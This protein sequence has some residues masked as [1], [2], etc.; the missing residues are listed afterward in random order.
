MKWR[1]VSVKIWVT[2]FFKVFTFIEYRQ[3][4]IER[5]PRD[6][7]SG[8]PRVMT[9][10]FV[11]SCFIWDIFV[12]YCE[13]YSFCYAYCPGK[14]IFPK[15]RDYYTVITLQ[16]LLRSSVKKNLFVPIGPFRSL[17]S[18][19]FLESFLKVKR[20]QRFT[21]GGNKATGWKTGMQ[22]KLQWFPGGSQQ[23]VLPRKRQISLQANSYRN[24]LTMLKT[25]QDCFI[26]KW[27]SH[28]H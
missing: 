6:E 9:K 4:Q 21:T 26:S 14:T 5:F 24:Y 2:N 22:S 1:S 20:A 27:R 7:K 23:R 25:A 12:A 8:W 3:V 28:R 18:T 10:D 19:K 13:W 16:L 17:R 11:Q 15:H